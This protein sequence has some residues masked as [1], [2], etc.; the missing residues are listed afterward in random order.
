MSTDKLGRSAG[1]AAGFKW[2]AWPALAL[3]VFIPIGVASTSP[4]LEWREPV[5]IIA[6]LAGVVAMSF[7]LLQPILVVG[8]LPGTKGVRGRRYH[9]WLG[10][11]LLA[12]VAIHIVGLWITSPPDVID[13]LLF[14]SP[15]PFS[16]WGVIAMWAVIGTAVLGLLRR[17]LNLKRNLWRFLHTAL[18]FVVVTG[19][20]IHALEIDGTMGIIS[21]A[22]L[23]ALTLAA[24][25][26]AMVELR[27]WAL[28]K[29]RST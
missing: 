20:V 22:V 13:A 29:R 6:G 28:L 7:L 8:F 3:A 27:S 25:I 19:G 9:R 14:R 5:Y 1:I 23:C 21:R 11:G 26:W 16:L 4:L 18:A 15:T 24:T 12:A 10:V 17:H 2:L